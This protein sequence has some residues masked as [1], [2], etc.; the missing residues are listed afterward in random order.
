MTK[1]LPSYTR[2]VTIPK[3]GL[4]RF[5]NRSVAAFA[6]DVKRAEALGWD[7]AFQNDSALGWRDPYVMLA[8]AAANTERIELAPLIVNPVT[9]HPAVL[10]SSI[11]TV[12]ELAPGRTLLGLGSGDNAVRQ[13]GLRPAKV[14]D[15]E[16]ATRLIKG[17]LDGESVEVGAPR[18]AFLQHHRPV[19][20][21]I[22][23]GGPRTLQMAGAYADGIFIRVGTSAGS[24]S[25][26][27]AEIRAGAQRVGR[28]P[29]SVRLGLIVD[30]VLVDD[31]DQALFMAKAMAAG[32]YELTPSS[33][34]V[35]GIR[36]DGPTI[37]HLKQEH[38]I[39]PD[40]HHHKDLVAAGRT[41]DFLPDA[42]AGLFSLWGGAAQIVAQA[43]AFIR[44]APVELD[45]VVLAPTPDPVWP[46]AG[47]QGYTARMAAEV[48]PALRQELQ[49]T[50]S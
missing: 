41:V 15:F 33:F 1:R 42:A 28:D 36:W 11:A 29:A 19:P 5:D 3:F 37:E 24:I 6:A 7:I 44:A 20:V 14:A 16:A 22:A 38:G 43:L 46:D 27:L 31:P 18:P 39:V 13:L 4:N 48:L 35:A 34:D 30:T 50:K 26:A 21:W 47:E 9:S 25:A 10:A 2:V 45:Y 17:L 49:A 23:A 40:F 8:A 12:D 32:H